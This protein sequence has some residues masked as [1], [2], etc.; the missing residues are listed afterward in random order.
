M[1]AWHLGPAAV[2]APDKQKGKRELWLH[3]GWS[4]WPRLSAASCLHAGRL[5]RRWRAPSS[6]LAA[7]DPQGRG[8]ARLRQPPSWDKCAPPADTEGAAGRRMA[9]WAWMQDSTVGVFVAE[10]PSFCACALCK[11][12]GGGGPRLPHWHVQH[13]AAECMEVRDSKASVP[14]SPLGSRQQCRRSG[15]PAAHLGDEIGHSG[16]P[17]PGRRC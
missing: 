3:S 16:F 5:L 15:P 2:A 7:S 17:N 4:C 11:D 13:A 8:R 14:Y 1:P 9:Q 10:S 12:T 6:T